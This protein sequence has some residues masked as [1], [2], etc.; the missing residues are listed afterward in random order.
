MRRE[1]EVGRVRILKWGP[2]GEEGRGEKEGGEVGSTK[3]KRRERWRHERRKVGPRVVVVVGSAEE[4]KKGA[5]GPRRRGERWTR[6]AREM[7]RAPPKNRT[8]LRLTWRPA[9][10]MG[11]KRTM[12]AARRPNWA[13][14]VET[15]LFF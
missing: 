3:E 9:R 10:P 13:A 15:I 12:Q 6:R 4:E 1:R 2:Q 7:K 14:A 8:L 11:R 5:E